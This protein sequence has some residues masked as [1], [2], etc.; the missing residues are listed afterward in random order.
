MTISSDKVPHLTAKYILF[1]MITN[2]FFEVYLRILSKSLPDQF[3]IWTK[4]NCL[5]FLT[6]T[7][8][9]LVR[10]WLI[11]NQKPSPHREEDR[12]LLWHHNFY[13]WLKIFVKLTCSQKFDHFVCFDLLWDELRVL[14]VQQKKKCVMSISKIMVPL[15][16]SGF[17]LHAFCFKSNT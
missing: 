9:T 12:G 8:H 2:I 14:W 17:L 3:N 13:D 4:S 7:D 10:G 16:F 11:P 15:K 6:I 1:R 5:I